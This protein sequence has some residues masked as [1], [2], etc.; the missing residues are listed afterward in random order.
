MLA[1]LDACRSQGVRDLVL[2]SSSEV[3]QTPR[4]VPTDERVPLSIPDPLNPRYSYGGGKLISELLTI[5][6]GR[7]GFDRVAIFRPHNAY[8]PAMGFEHVIPQLTRRICEIS[9]LT[10]KKISLP[11]QGDGSETRAFVFVDDIVS[12]MATVVERGEHLGIYNIG[13]QAEVTIAELALTIGELMG[14][15]VEIVAG[16]LQPGGTPRRCPDIA[17]LSA[18]G[19]APNVALREGL[20][21][22]VP[23]YV[24]AWRE[25]Q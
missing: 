4:S 9:G 22:T 18:L 7:T 6:Y 20:A 19:Y 5:N 10:Q 15:E 11:I 24:N 16:P 13:T 8:G 3:Y 21:R 2:A 1:V 23:W 12:G 17:K 25:Q 14:I